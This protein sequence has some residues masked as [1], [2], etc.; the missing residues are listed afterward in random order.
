MIF[1]GAPQ[2]SQFH[3]MFTALAASNTMMVNEMSDCSIIR[4]FAQGERICVSVGDNAVLVLN[5]RKR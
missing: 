3:S 1:G 5:E 4:A 2:S